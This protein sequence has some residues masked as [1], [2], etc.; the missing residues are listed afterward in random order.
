MLDPLNN[1]TE[2]SPGTGKPHL[3]YKASGVDIDAG[4]A[5][6]RRIKK[7]AQE[8][9]GPQV[10]SGLGGFGGLYQFPVDRYHQP[11]LVSSTDGVGTKLKL[12][13]LTGR[14]D[15]VGQDL[16]NH[17]VNDILTTGAEPLYFLDYYATDHLDGDIFEQV[18]KGLS[19]ACHENGCALIG[20]ET[21]E[22]PDFYQAGEYDISGTIVGVVEKETIL[23]GESI[24]AGDLLIGLPSNGLH[25]NGYSLARKALLPEWSVDTYV[26]DL[27]GTVGEAMLAIH[28]SYLRIMQPLLKKP[29]LHGMAHIT[30]GGLEGNTS[31]LLSSELQLAIDWDAWD[32]PKLFH[33]IQQAGG[34][35]DDDMKRTFN[36]GIGWVLVIDGEYLPELDQYLSEIGEE[37]I[38]VGTV[39]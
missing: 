15:T 32:W 19:I 35:G 30:G 2:N 1:L 27:G 4:E 23:T 5:A 16:V 21:A 14:H 3:S 29:W 17:C 20:G 8:T 34:V 10:L 26:S 11:V 33:V 9:H 22:M 13:Y 37:R 28:R 38:I 18:V 25:T 24:K 36:L 12:A 7:L 31:R 39:Q 6:V